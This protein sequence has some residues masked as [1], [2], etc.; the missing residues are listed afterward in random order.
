MFQPQG[1]APDILAAGRLALE[2]GVQMELPWPVSYVKLEKQI[3]DGT[4]SQKLVDDAVLAVFD[5]EIQ[6]RPL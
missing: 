5:G 3:T 2:A 6:T 4:I 1:I